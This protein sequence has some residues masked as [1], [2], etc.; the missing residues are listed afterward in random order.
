MGNEAQLSTERVRLADGA[1]TTVHVARLPRA[2]TRARVVVLRPPEPLLRWCRRTGC[3][4]AL[5]GGFF[6]RVTDQPLGRLWSDG[7]AMVNAPWG[8]RWSL[9]RGAIHIDGDSVSISPLGEMPID[10]VGDLLTAG[11]L[12]VRDRESLITDGYD[13][14]GIPETW[15]GELDADWTKVR[16]Q[17]SAIAFAGVH[18]FAVACEGPPV[19]WTPESTEAGLTIAELSGVLVELGAEAALNLDGGGGTSLVYEQRLVNCPRAGSVEP[20]RRHG[21]LIVEGRPLH[22]A[23]AFSVSAAS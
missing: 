15:R 5:T 12:L 17:R 3:Q 8:G 10:P 23:I 21:E 19:D 4:Y 13:F 18:L 9:R 1:T 6:S 2:I 14:E 7:V 11:P 20:D 22:T 16:A